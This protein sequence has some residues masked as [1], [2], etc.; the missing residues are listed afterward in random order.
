MTQPVERVVDCAVHPMFEHHGQIRDFMAEPY[1]SRSFPGP[2]RYF[3]P[4]PGG[5]YTDAALD[6]DGY[7]IADRDALLRPN[8][9][10]G[11]VTTAVL[12][13][14][15]R[16]LSPELDLGSAICSA[17]NQWLNEVWLADDRGG[18][19]RGSIRVNPGDPMA[20]V[21]E[22]ERWAGNGAMA[23]VAVPLEAHRPYGDRSYAPVWEAAA[24]Q[25]LPVCVVAD[26]G[27]GIELAPTA[28]GYPRH[29]IEYRTMQP[30]ATI[31]H[32]TSLLIEGM[33]TRF[34]DLRFVFLDGGA[35]V[36]MPLMWR[37]D[38]NW[39]STRHETPW[40]TDP[41]SELLDQHIRFVLQ[42][43]E[44]PTADEH[45][46]QWSEIG[47]WDRLLMY[48]S[49]YPYWPFA[50]SASVTDV[51]PPSVRARVLAANADAFYR[52]N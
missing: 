24:R 26:G 20:A 49:H 2:D 52:L 19:L 43:L 4:T 11:G 6:A 45:W 48:G 33:F 37:L 17:T 44:G 3:Y 31:Y 7:L 1:R 46:E 30:L 22:I 35:D 50:E 16:G 9:G 13:P 51:L 36:L 39:R 27:S 47:G 38:A 28:A 42:P 32:V 10:D 25:G 41:P 12:V 5:E 21:R 15:T 18:R 34:P 29:F 14:L 40:V 23:Q 8:L